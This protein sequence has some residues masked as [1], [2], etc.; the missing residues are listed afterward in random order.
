MKKIFFLSLASL[1]MLSCKTTQSGNG[2]GTN[3]LE[4]VDAKEYVFNA[5]MALP[6]G[7]KSVPLSYGYS[8]KVSGDTVHCY[9][10]YYGRAYV[11]PMTPDESGI[12][13]NT[14]DAKYSVKEKKSSRE[15]KIVASNAKG[16]SITLNLDIQASGQAS[17]RVNDPDLSVISYFGNVETLK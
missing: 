4:K 9:L 6:S 16:R 10:P 13:F 11:A 7:H 15:I 17:L 3:I 5:T 14:T 12:K 2:E 1:L 8:L